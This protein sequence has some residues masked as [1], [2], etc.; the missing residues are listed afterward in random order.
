MK[1]QM[2]IMLIGVGVLF[3]CLL[4]YKLFIGFLIKRSLQANR[5]PTITVSAMKVDYSPWQS[6]IKESGSL[7]AINGV[8]VTTSLAGMVQN[9]Y[10]TPGAV[11]KKDAV[12]VQLNADAE[13]GQLQSLQAQAANAKIIY[14][15]D[16]KQFAIHA[17]SKQAVDTDLQN[18]KSLIGQVAQQKAIVEKKT[19]RAPFSGRLGINL[20]NLGQYLNPGDTV[21]SLQSIDPIYADFYVPQQE[22]PKIKLGQTVYL[23]S[24]AFPGKRFAGKVTTINPAID[25][26]TRNI[27][28]EATV[29]NKKNE[30]TPGAFVNA[31]VVVGAAHK[32]LT[33][34]QTAISYNPYGDLVYVVT[35]SDQENKAK[36]KDSPDLIVKQRFI[37]LGETRGDQVQVLKGLK[38]GE[39]VVTSGQLKLKNG[40]HVKINNA[41]VPANS[42]TIITSNE[43]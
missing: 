21:T 16:Q 31:E 6:S 34:P 4:F 5:S 14:D 29:D 40:S 24:D 7:R 38:A 20:I 11:V 23:T 33:L 35:Q 39:T 43:H 41:V 17:V 15:R 8:N 42:P 1:K 18:L 25:I 9:I 30:L 13:V 19:I 32:D 22:L 3:G 26:T 28:V 12:L 36:D 27:Q 37:V 10:F 2:S